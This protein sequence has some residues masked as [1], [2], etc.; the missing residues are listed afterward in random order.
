MMQASGAYNILEEREGERDGKER[1]A[2][3]EQRFPR[4]STLLNEHI[5]TNPT[6]H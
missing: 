2:R 6:I 4:K 3:Q 5:C 1:G